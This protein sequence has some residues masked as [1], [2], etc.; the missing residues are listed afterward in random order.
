MAQE[1]K[2]KVQVDVED[3]KRSMDDVNQRIEKSRALGGN[4][5]SS[6]QNIARGAAAGITALGGVADQVAG[7]GLL[8]GLGGTVLGAGASGLRA[9]GQALG[10]DTGMLG[11]S[12]AEDRARSRASEAVKGLVGAGGDVSE[13]DMNRLLDE[14]TALYRP[15]EQNVQKLRMLEQDRA[16]QVVARGLNSV[17]SIDRLTTKIAELI[18]TIESWNPFRG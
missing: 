6:V 4:L 11:A 17:D 2:V 8:A 18:V 15:G 10:L 12:A 9:I 1:A 14:F 13:A 5:A 16:G 7:G 3:A